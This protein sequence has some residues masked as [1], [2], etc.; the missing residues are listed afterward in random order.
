MR[1][2]NGWP[3]VVFIDDS[4]LEMEDVKNFA[5]RTQN[6]H[7]DGVPIILLANEQTKQHVER[8]PTMSSLQLVEKPVGYLQIGQVMADLTNA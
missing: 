5:R 1:V 7:K 6:L 4:C 8:L 3:H 2:Q